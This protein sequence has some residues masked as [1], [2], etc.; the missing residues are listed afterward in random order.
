MTFPDYATTVFI[1]YLEN[2]LINCQRVDMIW[3]D[4]RETSLK[5]S[6]PVNRGAGRRLRVD[7]R[8]MTPSDWPDFLLTDGNKQELFLLV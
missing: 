7:S 4:Y 3:N 5:T 2:L 8:T 6:T 1:S